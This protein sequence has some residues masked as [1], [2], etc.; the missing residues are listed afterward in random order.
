[1]ISF[2][3]GSG[4]SLVSVRANKAG[5]KWVGCLCLL[6]YASHAYCLALVPSASGNYSINKRARL[7]GSVMFREL[8][9]D[10]AFP[11]HLDVAKAKVFG[12]FL[13]VQG[14]HAYL[15]PVGAL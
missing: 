14:I 9:K 5:G 8:D 4:L 15:S 7:A 10:D 12:A 11:S 2:I 13:R 6:S 1:M 3:F